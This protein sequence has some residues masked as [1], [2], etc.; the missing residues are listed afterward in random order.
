MIIALCWDCKY[1]DNTTDPTEQFCTIKKEVVGDIFMGN[2][3]ITECESFC[4][5]EL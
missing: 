2:T 1:F 3:T 5:V 4:K